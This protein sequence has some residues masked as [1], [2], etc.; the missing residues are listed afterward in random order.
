[1]R[2]FITISSK[3]QMLSTITGYIFCE[4]QWEKSDLKPV[5]TSGT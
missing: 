2:K 5:P 4:D 1:M 3:N